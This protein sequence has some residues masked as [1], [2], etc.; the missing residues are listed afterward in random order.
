MTKTL[1]A[2]LTIALG[3]TAGA[4]GASATPNSDAPWNQTVFETH[5]GLN[6]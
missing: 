6:R 2:A 5:L 4:F 1:I 3:V